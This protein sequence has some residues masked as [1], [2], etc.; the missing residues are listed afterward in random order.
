MNKQILAVV[1]LI[2]AVSVYYSGCTGKSAGTSTSVPTPSSTVAAAPDFTKLNPACF[3]ASS[4]NPIL[5]A[6]S[7]FSGADWNDPSVIKVGNQYVM[8]ATSDHNF[9]FN[10]GVYR[11][12]S[13]DSQNWSLSPT[14]PVLQANSD[15]TAWDAR[16]VETPSVVYFNGKYHLFYIGY[17]L[18]IGSHTVTY[19]DSYAY[20]IG[21][22]VSDDGIT[23]TRDS[24]YILAP[25]NP[26]T[27]TAATNPDVAGGLPFNQYVVGEPAPVVFQNKIY[28]YFTAIGANASVNNRL[29]VIGVMTSSDGSTWSAPQSVLI[30]DQTVYPSS[31]WQGYSTPSAIVLDGKVHLFFDVAQRSPWRQLK[32]THA[33]S[34]D[35]LS[36]WT[37]DATPIF[38]N[39]DFAWTSNEIRSPAALLDG[40]TLKLWFAGD[41][42]SV[43]GIGSASCSL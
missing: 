20:K 26:D 3:H 31:N 22:A 19:A 38:S 25:T 5:G 30:P 32:I 28:L 23:W 9:D 15:T 27:P 18:L 10:I 16:A 41:N 21:H 40:T 4:S 43:L 2:I 34:A 29:Q 14:T 24:S 36:G 17:P 33:S 37:L 35:G 12:V 1:I 42:S 39:T 8:Y 7:Q 11:L 13:S 6:N